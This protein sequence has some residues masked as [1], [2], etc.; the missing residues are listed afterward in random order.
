MSALSALQSPALPQ[1]TIPAK[2][3]CDAKRRYFYMQ[4][5]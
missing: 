4:A 2:V 1:K 3:G 5:K